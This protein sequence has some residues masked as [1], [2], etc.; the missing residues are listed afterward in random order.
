MR[1]TLASSP[2]IHHAELYFIFINPMPQL[3]HTYWFRAEPL[4]SVLPLEVEKKNPGGGWNWSWMTAAPEWENND[5]RGEAGR[6]WQQQQGQE[7]PV[8]AAGL[9]NEQRKCIY[10]NIEGD[11]FFFLHTPYKI[12]FE[13]VAINSLIMG[14][15]V[16]P[17]TG[18]KLIPPDLCCR[19]DGADYCAAAAPLALTKPH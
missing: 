10:V 1:L 2:T 11:L 4:T 3:M 7:W 13:A 15:T 5:P 12:T 9:F 16:L 14:L 18:D 17:N 6:L 8:E 19:A